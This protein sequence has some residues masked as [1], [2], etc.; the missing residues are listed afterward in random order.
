MFQKFLLLLA[1]ATSIGAASAADARN[2]TVDWKETRQTI[3]GFG[4]SSAWYS[5]Q[6]GK[7]DPKVRQAAIKF[8]FDQETGIGLSILRIRLDPRPYSE[9]TRE[10]DWDHE[11]VEGSM[12]FYR[13][14]MTYKPLV[15]ASPWSPPEWMKT[16]GR[17]QKDG[18]L[19][20]EH[21]DSYAEYLSKWVQ[22]L[23]KQAG[24]KVD[25]LSVQ[26]EPGKKSWECC[27]W[28]ADDFVRFVGKH[29]A[30]RLEADGV[31]VKVLA[32]EW[33]GWSDHW[34][35]ALLKDP[36][37]RKRF[38]IAGAHLYH[39]GFKNIRPFPELKKAGIP[40][41]MTEH[42]YEGKTESPIHCGL[43]NAKHVHEI[44]TIA[45]GNAYVFWWLYGPKKKGRQQSLIRIDSDASEFE[46][47]KQAYA[48]GNFSRFVRPG[49][50]RL[51]MSKPQPIDQVYVTAFR[52]P[53][54]G[55]FA[56]IIN[57]MSKAAQQLTL[58]LAGF[59]QAQLVPY[60]TSA[61]E[62]L[63]K[64]KPVR[65]K[66]GTCTLDLPPMSITSFVTE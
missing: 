7:F 40:L 9:Q 15:F 24:M 36:D 16:S 28:K 45:D 1:A 27:E 18:F 61:D 58:D 2:V 65:T 4:A 25:V 52:H 38:D 12:A 39:G 42:Y 11:K 19:K 66:E 63:A 6:V 49:F 57:N 62:D 32:A 23:E 17:T 29:L 34:M 13:G 37:A 50:V 22:S 43:I 59:P 5:R 44:F 53:K 54:D 8:A 30:D 33:T 55:R 21:F 10:Y 35:R 51:H 46:P 14:V 48:F 41:W 47:K 26:N 31:D 60:R 56:I 20:Q 64:L 3:D